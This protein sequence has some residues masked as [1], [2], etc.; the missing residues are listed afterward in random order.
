MIGV[1]WVK[2]FK[3]NV[4]VVGCKFD[5][6]LYSFDLVIYGVEDEFDYKAVEGFIYVWGL[7]ICVWLEKF[8]G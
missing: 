1:V 3:G 7:L 6:F 2:L 8:W 4:M 5:N